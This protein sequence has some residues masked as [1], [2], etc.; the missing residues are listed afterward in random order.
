[1]ICWIDRPR[2]SGGFSAT[3]IWPTLKAL[4]LPSLDRSPLASASSWDHIPTIHP[5]L[6]FQPNTANGRSALNRDQ[7]LRIYQLLQADLSKRKEFGFDKKNSRIAGMRCQFGQPV[8]CGHR[9]GVPVS[10]LRICASM[11]MVVQATAHG[12]RDAGL[13]IEKAVGALEKAALL[14]KSFMK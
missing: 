8:A 7:T 5:F 3:I 6:L 12:E 1:M 4:P 11:R 10:A 9:D 2:T 13:V 14:A